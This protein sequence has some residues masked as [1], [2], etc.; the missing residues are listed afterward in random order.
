M[1]EKVQIGGKP[2]FDNPFSDCTFLGRYAG[3][4]LYVDHSPGKTPD[5]L[6]RSGDEPGDSIEGL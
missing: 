5:V 4:D 6:A 3:Y 1:T 2:T